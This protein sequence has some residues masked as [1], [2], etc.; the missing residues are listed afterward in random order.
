MVPLIIKEQ[1]R[2]DL[3]KWPSINNEDVITKQ[4]ILPFRPCLDISLRH[5]TKKYGV[6]PLKQWPHP[7][8][9]LTVYVTALNICMNISVILHTENA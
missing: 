6:W 9:Y 7:K 8:V 1:T 3:W 5:S 2:F 4:S